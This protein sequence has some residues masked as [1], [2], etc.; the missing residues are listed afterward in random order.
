MPEQYHI[1]EIEISRR[2]KAFTSMILSLFVFSNL[3]YID[4]IFTHFP[5][6]VIFSI[7][8]GIV[9]YST[10]LM[11][12]KFLKSFARIKVVL[13]ATSLIREFEEHVISCDFKDIKLIK[14][15][16]TSRGFIREIKIIADAST[17]VHI[18]G[19][20]EFDRFEQQLL[21]K[22][23]Q[24]TT[25]R[26]ITEAVDYDHPLFYPVF[27]MLVSIASVYSIRIVSGLDTQNVIV[28]LYSILLVNLIA[29]IFIF[30]YKPFTKTFGNKRIHLDYLIGT[31]IILA[32]VLLY[33]Y[34]QTLSSRG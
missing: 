1:S 24:S 21:S 34:F 30:V 28:F 26:R 7:G 15:K 31:I 33:L 13:T 6:S 23:D 22:L 10:R 17:D 19:L 25:I 2:E 29:S 11:T 16:R 5:T 20:Y 14:I 12:F 9:L 18:N 32:D 3:F 8:V 4:L 27:G